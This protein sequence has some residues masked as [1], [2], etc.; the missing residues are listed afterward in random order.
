VVIITWD[1]S[2]ADRAQSV[3]AS[4]IRELLKFAQRPEIISFAGG[5]PHPKSFPVEDIFRISQSVLLNDGAQ[6][7]QY[8]ETEGYEELRRFLAARERSVGV[9]SDEENILVTSGSQQGLELVAKTFVNPGDTVLVEE[10]GYLGGLQAFR[11]F[12]AS[13]KT[14]PLLEDGADLDALRAIL[15]KGEPAPKLFYI[16]PTFQNP[17]GITYSKEKRKELAEIATE[18]NLIVVEDN[19]YAKLRFEGDDIRSFKA[20]CPDNTIYLSSFSKILSPGFRMAW[21]CAPKDVIKKLTIMKQATDLC[22]NTYSQV[23]T[24]ELLR[25]GLI[26]RHIPWIAAMYKE[27][28]D[29][30]I[31]AMEEYFPPEATWTHPEGGMFLWVTLPQYVNTKEMFKAALKENVA[32]V[33]GGAFFIKGGENHMRLTFSYVDNDKIVEGIKRLAMVIAAHMHG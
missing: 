6:A 10:P 20:F 7:L 23:I 16:V 29:I 27:K 4:D 8:S 28:R 2:Y 31:K 9:L 5:M 13:F 26:D 32:Y 12:Q 22:S 17:S 3:K 18:H 19:P 30:M 25:R 14:V 15:K 21:V 33:H 1:K 24:Y 11:M